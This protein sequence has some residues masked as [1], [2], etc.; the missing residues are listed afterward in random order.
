MS[1]DGYDIRDYQKE[2]PVLDWLVERLGR[3]LPDDEARVRTA[4]DD[5]PR[6]R[7]GDV[8]RRLP[9]HR[10]PRAPRSRG[11]VALVPPPSRRW[12]RRPPL[13]G[14]EWCVGPD[15]ACVPPPSCARRRRDARTTVGF[16][17]PARASIVDPGSRRDVTPSG[18]FG[19]DDNHAEPIPPPVD[20][21]LRSVP[22][23][24]DLGFDRSCSSRTIRTCGCSWD[25]ASVPIRASQSPRTPPTRTTRWASPRRSPPTSSCSTTSSTA[26][27]PG[28]ASRRC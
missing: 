7:V 17:A 19:R 18:W 6:R 3:E 15:P 14:A 13:V 8:R 10:G 12:S 4:F 27:S 24:R 21:R 11:V 20:V 5:R 26:T 9:R 1:L 2:F 25:F 16:G 28:C 23:R 22:W